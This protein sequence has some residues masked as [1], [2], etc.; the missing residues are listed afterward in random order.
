MPKGHLPS[1]SLNRGQTAASSLAEIDLFL[2]MLAAER[3]AASNTM[4]A[5]RRDL[6]DA[7]GFLASHGK[8]LE[9]ADDRDLRGYLASLSSRGLMPRSAARRLSALRQF[10]R[11]LFTE[12]RRQDDPTTSLDRPRQGR[13]LPKTLGEEEVERLLTAARARRGP[14]GLRLSLLVELLYATGLRVSELVSLPRAAVR[15]DPRVLIVQGKGGKE[16]MIPLGDAARAALADY[17]SVAGRRDGSRTAS[18]AWLFP[19]HGREGHLTRRR[20]GQLLKELALEAG[21]DPD[22]VSPHV[23]RHAFASHLLDHGADLRSVQKMLG[24]AD[25]STTQIYTHVLSARLQS[26]V[27]EKHPLAQS[28]GRNR[29]S[30]DAK[31]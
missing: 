25:I 28:G 22:K 9:T 8:R 18:S 14:D 5:Y 16:R 1:A 7:A 29:R 15:R 20:V 13:P 4:A 11:F 30:N 21:L 23:L 27:Q 3:G 26:L 6:V 31:R 19:S 10:F 24:H 17:L 12:G 2:E